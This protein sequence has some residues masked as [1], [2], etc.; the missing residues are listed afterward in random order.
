MTHS[1]QYF[2][3]GAGAIIIDG[4]GRV[5]ALE[6]SDI[7]NA[8][9]MP[10]GGLEEGEEPLPAVLRE[11]REETG[12]PS[13]QLELVGAYPE[14]LAYELP[15]HARSQKTGRGQVQ[16]WFLLKLTGRGDAIDLHRSTEFRAWCWMPLEHLIDEAVEFRVPIYRRLAAYFSDHLDVE[17]RHS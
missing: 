8:W 12:I 17:A 4:S 16:Y 6:R 11:I 15:P 10:Q 7:P 14:L 5:L 13:S 2:R 3:A 1:G 9:Q